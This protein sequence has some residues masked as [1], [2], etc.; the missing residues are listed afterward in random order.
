MQSILDAINEWIKEILIGAIN[1]NLSTMF[2]DVNEKVGTIANEVGQTP[3][4]WNANIF[5]M[6]QTLSENVIVP[7]AGLVIT[8]VL[9][10]EL[11][12][13]VTEKNNMHDIDTFMFFKW[14][15]KAFVAVFIVT[16]TFNITMAVFDM[17]QHIVSGA[18]GVIGGDTNIDVA[19][20]LAAM[21]EG[22]EDMEIPELLLLVLETSLVSLCM[23][24][25]SVLITVILYGRM[26]EIYLY[27]SVSPIPFATMTNREWGQIG[28]NYLKGLFA[29][30]F[31]GFLIMIC[32]GIYAV[33]VNDMIIADNL[34]SAVYGK[35]YSFPMLATKLYP[36]L[37]TTPGTAN[38]T[39]FPKRKTPQSATFQS[40]YI[41]K[42]ERTLFPRFV[43]VGFL[44]SFCSSRQDFQIFFAHTVK[45]S[46]ELTA[47]RGFLLFP[48]REKELVY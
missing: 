9:C 45:H 35:G 30:G 25:M 22:L 24:I 44:Y 40:L 7:I 33:L 8:Y 48:F 11:I 16:N 28:N 29:L 36:L 5:S 15:F 27:C 47:A 41:N 6:I 10:Y 3:Q 37:P 19:E 14:I 39:N 12:S 43:V 2:G 26:I 4:G 32:V 38:L 18:A 1:G 34:H 23:K 31:Q 20:A 46:I 21:Q 42:N 17:A 13:M